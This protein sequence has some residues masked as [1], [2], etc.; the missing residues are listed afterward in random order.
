MVAHLLVDKL[1][2][3]FQVK[4]RAKMHGKNSA[5]S[6]ANW[7]TV[8]VDN[9]VE[10]SSYGPCPVKE[11]EWIEVN[12]VVEIRVGRLIKPLIHNYT[13]EIQEQLAAEHIRFEIS[14]QMLRVFLF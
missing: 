8:P 14:G 6:W 10:A 7:F 9:Y 13:S 3:K 4:T 11:V 2:G 1:A 5:S 12:P